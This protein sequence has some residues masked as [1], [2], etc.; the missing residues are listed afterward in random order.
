MLNKSD[1]RPAYA[2]VGQNSSA[3]NRPQMSYA[4][5]SAAQVEDDDFNA[6]GDT[7]ARSNASAPKQRQSQPTKQPAPARRPQKK[8][9]S[10]SPKMIIIGVAA[11]VALILVIALFVAIFSSPGKNITREDDVYATYIDENDVYHVLHNGKEIKHE[12]DGKVALRPAK[13]YSFAY[14]TEEIVADDGTTKMNIYILKGK[15]IE[16]IEGHPTS[17]IDYAD[18]EPGII[19]KENQI[20]KFHSDNADEVVTSNAAAGNF[21][22]SGDASTIV[23]T[24]PT[25]RDASTTHLRYFR[26]AGYNDIGETSGLIPKAIS[27]DGK[28][29]Y[30]TDSTNAFYYLKVTKRGADYEQKTIMATAPGVFGEVTELNVAGDEVVFTYLDGNEEQPQAISIMYKIGDK[31]AKQL[32]D[33][34]VFRYTPIDKEVV[35]PATFD[36]S[37]FIVNRTILNEDEEPINVN[38]TFYYT[39]DE[40]FRLADTEGSFSADGKFFYFLESRQLCRVSLSSKNYAEDTEILS[41]SAVD[42][43]GLA[44]NG[45]IYT[46]TKPTENSP[47]SISWRK[48]DKT[49]SRTVSATADADSMYVCGNAVFFSETIEDNLKLYKAVGDSAKEE[50]TFKKTIADTH[51]TI[52]MGSGDKGYAYFT[53]IDGITK[54]LYTSNGKSFDIVCKSCTIPGYNSDSAVTTPGSDSNSDSSNTET[55]ADDDTSAG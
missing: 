55:P 22:I 15:K 25:G 46:Y 18:Y 44:E 38:S 35:C 54:L 34:G 49:K 33:S 23:Y 11:L 41:G 14:V 4:A 27:K 20:I 3:N 26:S 53:D 43:F 5:F 24:E 13:N 7:S 29:V 8:G 52:I 2:T 17:V 6:F 31:K 40:A 1:M 39:R 51:M 45:D 30:A 21:L 16:Q 32:S 12:F 47:G 9:F 36:D 48:A 50:I 28:Y 10:P 37:A 42:D 19:Y